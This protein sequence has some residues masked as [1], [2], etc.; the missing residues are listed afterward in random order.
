MALF[1]DTVLIESSAGFNNFA[2]KNEGLLLVRCYSI[3]GYE[4]E[5]TNQGDRLFE[6]YSAVTYTQLQQIVDSKFFT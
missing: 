1:L 5:F 6:V 3:G 4:G 2:N